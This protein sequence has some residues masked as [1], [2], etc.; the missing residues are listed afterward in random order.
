MPLAATEVVVSRSH[1]PGV[2]RFGPL[3]GGP[4]GFHRSRLR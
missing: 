3:S 1:Q 4:S 2:G